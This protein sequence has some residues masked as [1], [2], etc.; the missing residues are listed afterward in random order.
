MDSMSVTGK[1][2]RQ[3][4]CIL[5]IDS[6][7]T[8]PRFL[9]DLLRDISY[10]VGT[11][12]EA[13]SVNLMSGE[14]KGKSIILKV[15]TIKDAN[16][17]VEAH[18]VRN[19]YPTINELYN[20]WAHTSSK[21]LQLNSDYVEDHNAKEYNILEITHWASILSLDLIELS[22][23]IHAINTNRDSFSTP[24]K[25]YI[26]QMCSLLRILNI[27]IFTMEGI[28]KMDKPINDLGFNIFKVIDCLKELLG[29]FT[30]HRITLPIGIPYHSNTW[31]NEFKDATLKLVEAIFDDQEVPDGFLNDLRS[32]L[33]LGRDK[34][35]AFSRTSD[36]PTL[37]SSKVYG[38]QLDV[39]S[40]LIRI[41]EH[42]IRD[43]AKIDQCRLPRSPNNKSDRTSVFDELMTRLPI[44]RSFTL[45][46]HGKQ[47]KINPDAATGTI[48][49]GNIEKIQD[50]IIELCKCKSVEDE[51]TDRTSNQ[52]LNMIQVIIKTAISELYDDQNVSVLD[53]ALNG[54]E[55]DLELY[56]QYA[57][58]NLFRRFLLVSHVDLKP[59]FVKVHSVL[60]PND[61][62]GLSNHL[63][64]LMK[65]AKTYAFRKTG[66]GT[67]TTESFAQTAKWL[68]N[69]KGVNNAVLYDTMV[70][71]GLRVKTGCTYQRLA[72]DLIKSVKEKFSLDSFCI[73]KY[74]LLTSRTDRFP[75]FDQDTNKIPV[76]LYKWNFSQGPIKFNAPVNWSEMNSS[77]FN[78]GDKTWIYKVD[79]SLKEAVG[80][81]LGV[82]NYAGDICDKDE[83]RKT[84]TDAPELRSAFHIQNDDCMS[85]KTKERAWNSRSCNGDFE[86]AYNT[87]DIQKHPNRVA[88]YYP[89]C[90]HISL[91][92]DATCGELSGG[93]GRNS[94]N[95]EPNRSVREWTENV[96][97]TPWHATLGIH[98]T[99]YL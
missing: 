12:S 45:S 17:N 5:K 73:L 28:I 18:I 14:Y 13:N 56:R 62:L 29:E 46:S 42:I 16:Q 26:H 63:E 95:K 11:S 40:D 77:N 72:S 90:A 93:S 47:N 94:Q 49:W 74:S 15:I 86:E 61:F 52:D 96:K 35:Q 10:S 78:R 7:L 36:D 85:F 43:F 30:G 25:A 38:A 54:I 67:L 20:A 92:D 81:M 24:F 48:D 4:P 60:F 50:L 88:R 9:Q 83:V 55:M 75:E 1:A 2:W 39:T 87:S 33:I 82:F 53:Q 27:A 59:I 69:L 70:D 37:K 19:F 44:T 8:K 99:N 32:R 91:K 68:G 98:S 31:Q 51:N 57:I 79:F 84:L 21:Y 22:L 65:V 41:C 66:S 89:D 97:G 3:D 76:W 34:I 71:K 6:G 58:S 64:R 23:I 80:E